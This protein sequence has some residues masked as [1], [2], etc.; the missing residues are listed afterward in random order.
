MHCHT[1]FV[2]LL[3]VLLFSIIKMR[4]IADGNRFCESYFI[5]MD[6][7][8]EILDKKLKCWAKAL[9]RTIGMSAKVFDRNGQKAKALLTERLVAAFDLCSAI[10]YL[11]NRK[12]IHR[13]IK[14]RKKHGHIAQFTCFLN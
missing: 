5:V 11:H 9:S 12:I 1:H 2:F 10:Q 3:T 4:A 14:V 13:D 7:L 8:Y 6:R